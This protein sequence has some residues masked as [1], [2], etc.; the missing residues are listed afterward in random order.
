M[1]TLK[2][3]LNVDVKLKVS[4]TIKVA[5]ITDAIPCRFKP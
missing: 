4:N 1:D 2:E 3:N 5:T